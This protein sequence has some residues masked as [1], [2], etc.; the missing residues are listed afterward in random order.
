MNLTVEI[1]E[2]HEDGSATI[3]YEADK[4]A[5]EFLMGQGLL[6]LIKQGLEA[7]EKLYGA[8]AGSKS[9]DKS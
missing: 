6:Y 7:E 2:E 5:K 1:M 4:E 9:Q 3:T 8:N